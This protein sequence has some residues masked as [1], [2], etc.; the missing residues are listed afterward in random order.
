MGSRGTKEQRIGWQWGGRGA[1]VLPSGCFGS[2]VAG[3]F[4]VWRMRLHRLP[5]RPTVLALRI[6]RPACGACCCLRFCRETYV[7]QEAGESPNDRNDRAI[8]VAAA[9]YTA[10]LPGHK[11]RRWVGG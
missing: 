5:R 7:K 10:R 2:R 9:W 11:V 6:Q 1:E 4:A 3:W 8:R